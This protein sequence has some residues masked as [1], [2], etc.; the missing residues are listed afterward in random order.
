MLYSALIIITFFF[1]F[2]SF[3]HKNVSLKSLKQS[4]TINIKSVT[5]INCEFSGQTV[6]KQKLLFKSERFLLSELRNIDEMG[7]KGV[8][9]NFFDFLGYRFHIND[10]KKLVIRAE[11]E[12]SLKKV[13]KDY[14]RLPANLTS[15][16][17]FSTNVN[18]KSINFKEVTVV[19]H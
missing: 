3:A 2:K 13:T 19:C 1:S 8:Y 9:V 10:S 4:P 7:N 5:E 17:S 15:K 11:I 18:N 6:K 14:S 16:V 12:E